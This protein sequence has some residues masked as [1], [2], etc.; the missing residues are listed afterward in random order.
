[1]MTRQDRVTS[2]Y[3]AYSVDLLRYIRRLTNGHPDAEDIHA[4]LFLEAIRC[5][6]FLDDAPRAW[7]YQTAQW[8]VRDWQKWQMRRKNDVLYDADM[9]TTCIEDR[10][11]DRLLVATAWRGTTITPPQRMA[12]WHVYVEDRPIH[13]VAQW[14][15]VSP[16]AVKALLHRARIQLSRNFTLNSAPI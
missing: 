4:A 2:W 11:I 5:S 16:G 6:S 7:F 15:Q 13:E 1:M 14:M 10:T 12:F 3:E 9:S 8:R